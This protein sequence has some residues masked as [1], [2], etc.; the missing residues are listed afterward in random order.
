MADKVAADKVAADKADEK[1]WIG[2]FCGSQSGYHPEYKFAAYGLGREIARRG[3]GLI[4][5]GSKQGLMGEVSSAAYYGGAEVKGFLP[6]AM[7]RDKGVGEIEFVEGLHQRQCITMALADACIALPGG[8]GTLSEITELV[9]WYILGIHQKPIGLLNTASFYVPLLLFIKH[10]VAAGFIAPMYESLLVVDDTP[11][12]LLDKVM[13]HKLPPSLVYAWEEVWGDSAGR[14]S[15]G[16]EKKQG[17]K[18][19]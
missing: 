1:K 13:A 19:Q 10:Q 12:I 8:F 11:R 3:W 5:G 18:K 2:L 15:E 4:Y 14:N 17:G 6:E 9:T 7:G 16:E